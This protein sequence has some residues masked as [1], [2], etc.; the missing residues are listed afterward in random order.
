MEKFAVVLAAGKGTRM[1]TLDQDKSKV[2]FEIFDKHLADYVLDSLETAEIKNIVVVA[3][4]GKEETKKIVEDRSTVVFQKE[5]NGTAKAVDAARGV[6]EK[7]DGH[8]I[9]ICG[10]TPLIKSSTISA[11]FDYHIKNKC[12]MT[13]ATM[14]LD[15]P[16]GYGRIVRNKDGSVEMIVEE[17]D[18][19]EEQKQIHEVN[20][21]LY[22]F[23][24]KLLFEY[25]NEIDCNNKQKEYYLTDVIKVF[26][27][28]GKKIGAF[29][30]EDSNEMLGV[31]DRKQLAFARKI[32]QERVNDNLMLSGVTIEDPN[33]TYISP[34]VKIGQD[35]TI[36]PNTTIL[37]E[38]IIGT[39]NYIG[40]NSYLKNVKIGNDNNVY[41]SWLTDFTCGNHNE[42]G[43]FTKSRAVTI[44]EN[45]CRI[46][47]F[48]ELKD[49]YFHNGVKCAHLTYIGD[50]EIGEATN[51][52]CGTITANYDGFNKMRTT[53][54]KESFIGSGTILVAPVKVE[55]HS[56]TAAGSTITKDVK[57]DS[58]AIARGRQVDIEHGYSVFRKKARALKESLE[59]DKK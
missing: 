6:L 58:M 49:A 51:V 54:G 10:D 34:K 48:V 15:K 43:P 7:K 28:K 35:T 11:L 56:F 40:P 19:N 38:S 9:V 13:V 4:F 42:I 14:V 18:A 12:D 1:K 23:N 25:I 24:N 55:D 36:G 30:V 39:G 22:V 20:S 17:K 5:I 2:S 44:V 29:V 27:K 32:I 8:T 26:D 3:G 21:G 52:G 47:N 41:S 57:E 59:K 31:N 45:N 37:G 50:T 16:Y 46:G 33:T 53:I